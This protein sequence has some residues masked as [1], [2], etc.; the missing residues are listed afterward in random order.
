MKIKSEYMFIAISV[1]ML[2]ILVQ[3]SRVAY[4]AK[5]AVVTETETKELDKSEPIETK[6]VDKV[7]DEVKTEP[8]KEKV[9]VKK[10][11]K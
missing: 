7:E 1:I 4:F 2:A 6:Q 8:V 9:S 5:K 3:V 10:D 11:K